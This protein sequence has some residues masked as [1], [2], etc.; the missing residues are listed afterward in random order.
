VL[1]FDRYL[2]RSFAHVF[3]VCFIATFGLVVVF[4]LLENLDDFIARNGDGGVLRLWQNVLQYYGYQALFFLNRGGPALLVL[5]VVVV[6]LLLRKSGE[7]RPLLAAGIPMFR[8]LRPLVLAAIC[9]T[10]GLV[11]NQEVIIPKIA[12][13]AY[14]SRGGASRTALR[15]EPTYDRESRISIDG[16]SIRLADRTIEQAEFVLPPPGICRELTIIKAA[17]AT[18]RSSKHGQPAGWVLNQVSLTHSELPLTELGRKIIRAGRTPDEL[19]VVTSVTCDQLYKRNSSY[20]LLSTPELL[21]RIRSP[22]VGLLSAQ[23]LVAH[24]HSRFVQPVLNVMLVM[25]V[26]PL[27]IRRE[28]T[29]MVVDAALSLSVLAGLL[30]SAQLATLLG[31]AQ[32]APPELLAWCPVLLAGT[33]AAWCSGWIET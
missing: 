17:T 10:I 23:R 29:G 13:A 1:T 20:T 7:L 2:F 8:V 6:L 31:Q 12:F 33:A 18:H 28:S 26:F 30:G 9:V 24:V 19:F 21:R 11:V 32:V 27:V 14:E 16:K 5:S 4:D 3:S 15:V 22:A 25:L